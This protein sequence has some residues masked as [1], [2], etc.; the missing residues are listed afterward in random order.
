MENKLDYI[1]NIGFMRIGQAI[2]HKQWK[3]AAMTLRSLEREAKKVGF[4]DFD[5][6]F[7]KLRYAISR[8]DINAA[9]QIL[10]FITNKR[11]KILNTTNE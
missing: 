2:A 6:Y 3:T 9:K 5:S 10:T 1:K 4:S 7:I 11:V 8:E